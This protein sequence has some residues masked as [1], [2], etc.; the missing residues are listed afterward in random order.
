MSISKLSA[1]LQC[2]NAFRGFYAKDSFV[3]VHQRLSL[4]K[5]ASEVGGTLSQTVQW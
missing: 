3:A 4:Q 5:F 2:K 1:D